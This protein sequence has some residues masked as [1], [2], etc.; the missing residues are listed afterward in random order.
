MIYTLFESYFIGLLDKPI[1]LWQKQ[2]IW[3]FAKVML[4]K[5]KKTEEKFIIFLEYY[6]S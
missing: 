1:Y 6:A 5:N 3:P 2:F 4:R